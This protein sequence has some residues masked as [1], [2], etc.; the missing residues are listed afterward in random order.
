[1]FILQRIGI[2]DTINSNMT[3][4]RHVI[5]DPKFDLTSIFYATH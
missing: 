1:M 5:S 4:H 2:L 3:L